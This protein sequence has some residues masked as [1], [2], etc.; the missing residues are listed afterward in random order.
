MT[1]KRK[2]YLSYLL[3]LWQ[4]GTDGEAIW[5]ASLESAQTGLRQDFAELDALFCYL[6]E[7]MANASEQKSIP[8]KK[9]DSNDQSEDSYNKH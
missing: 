3:R 4:E 2:P 6:R 1:R 9:G 5:R 8:E 7:Q